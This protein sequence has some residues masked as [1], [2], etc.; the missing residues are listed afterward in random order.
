M[1]ASSTNVQPE[2][3]FT[4]S[5]FVTVVLHNVAKYLK[6]NL[7]ISDDEVEDLF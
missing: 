5:S 2:N 6:D 7:P 1:P 3:S 4:K